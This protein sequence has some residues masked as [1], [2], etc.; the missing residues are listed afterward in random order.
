MLYDGRGDCSIGRSEESGMYFSTGGNARQIL[1][2]SWAK[3]RGQLEV[4]ERGRGADPLLLPSPHYH[5]DL[6]F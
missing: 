4:W 2:G 5:A 6:L 3:L 1:D